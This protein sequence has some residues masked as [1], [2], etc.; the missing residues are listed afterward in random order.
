MLKAAKTYH[1]KWDSCQIP[2]NIARQLPIWF[3][4]G[5][6]P[7]LNKLNN[8]YYV[9]CLR[10]KHKIVS[11]GDLEKATQQTPQDHK[12]RK[13]C[14]CSASASDR[15][16]YECAKPFRC[17]KTANEI[18]ACILPKWSTSTEI[19]KKVPDLTPEQHEANK[20]ALKEK[21]KVLFDPALPTISIIEDGFRA[22]TSPTH[23]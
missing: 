3:H 7:E 8:Y 10:D 15:T 21:G 17:H 9:N 19:F 1:V 18:L 20:K 5:A 12:N 14:E 11:V 2:P 16:K 6:S 22:F 23:S 13:E 4:L